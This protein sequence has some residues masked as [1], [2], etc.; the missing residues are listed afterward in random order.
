M[1]LPNKYAGLTSDLQ[2]HSYDTKLLCVEVGSRGLITDLNMCFF[3]IHFPM[4]SENKKPLKLV[5][6]KKI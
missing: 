2:E 3:S 1:L 4:I 5:S 6:K